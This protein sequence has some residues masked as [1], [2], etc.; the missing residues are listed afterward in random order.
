MNSEFRIM[1]YLGKV[2][3]AAYVLGFPIYSLINPRIGFTVFYRRHK[4]WYAYTRGRTIQVR[5]AAL[6]TLEYFRQSIPQPGDTVFD[7]G[8]ELGF[9]TEQFAQLVGPSGKVYTFECLPDHVARLN[10]IA[11]RYPNVTVIERACWNKTTTI[12]FSVGRTPGSG[13][14]VPDARGQVG[15]VLADPTKTKLV[16]QAATLD[17]LWAEYANSV[18]IDFLKMDIEGAEYEAIEGAGE[19]LKHTSRVVVAAYHIRDGVRTAD[20]VAEILARNG[21]VAAIHENNH[22]YAYRKSGLSPQQK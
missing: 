17:A 16:V 6:W 20:R 10:E 3:K 5:D 14:A 13:T 1:S 15:Q 22:V 4:V 11:K 7:V 9:E 8:G 21:F 12:E 18:P 19:L 2:K